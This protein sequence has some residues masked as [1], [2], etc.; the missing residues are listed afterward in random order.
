MTDGPTSLQRAIAKLVTGTDLAEDEAAGCMTE[1]M[2]GEAT[3][4]Q[5]AA[6][7]TALR[8]K[9]ETID[10]I[11]GMARVMRQHSQRVV[12][13]G[14][15]LDTCGTG[16]DDSGS[17]NVSTCAAF[18]AA[19]AGARVAKHGNRAMTSQCGSADVLEALGAKI[20]LTPEQV[21][22]CIE[23]TGIGFAFA[24]TFHPAMKHVAPARREIGI[25]TVFNLLGPLTNPAGARR[26]VLGVPR[27]D[28]VEH[29]AAVLQR[30]GAERALVVHGDD[31]FDEVSI[32]GATTIAQLSEDGIRS[33]RVAPEDA[34]LPAHDIGA[35]RGGT[36]E[37]NA[38]ELRL[39]LEGAPGALRDFALMNAGAALIAWGA[40][41]E[42]AAGVRLAAT[43]VDS[44]AALGKLDAFVTATNEVSRDA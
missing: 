5:F 39:V 12:I 35:L 32:S 29:L 41:D 21:R 20:E 11:A 24:Q 19:G 18:I 26:Q 17:F 1:L 4:A 28:L 23:R 34:D 44:G 25:R 27:P 30:L 38:A 31:G 43:S 15:L 2:S 3:P 40:A 14:P 7:A 33:Y 36:R 10:E 9:G 37:Q 42:F 13:E 6:Y 22:T 16:G 8:I